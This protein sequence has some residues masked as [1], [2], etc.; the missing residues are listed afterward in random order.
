MILVQLCGYESYGYTRVF[1]R[2]RDVRLSGVWVFFEF[3][4]VAYLN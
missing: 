1:I 4:V 3:V 2:E